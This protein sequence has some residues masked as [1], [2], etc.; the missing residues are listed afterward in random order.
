MENK[1]NQILTSKRYHDLDLARAI[2][3]L[4]L[5]FIHC[6]EEFNAIHLLSPTLVERGRIFLF[7]CMICPSVFM[8]ELGMNITFSTHTSDTELAHRG[9]R[10]ILYFYLLNIAR[11]G[12]PAIVFGLIFK[13][14]D[15]IKELRI[16][17][18]Q[19]DILFFAGAAFLFFALMKHWNVK[20]YH[21][22][23]I[24]IF[25]LAL[26]ILIPNGITQNYTLR[27][28][29]GNIFYVSSGS[30]FPLLSWLIFPTVGYLM[31]GYL[32]KLPDEKSINSFFR[33]MLFG[34]I[35]VLLCTAACLKNYGLNPL[36]IAT[37]PAN[38]YITDLF[39]VL[40]DLAIAG[41]WFSVIHF[42]YGCIH[43]VR[44]KRVADIISRGIL[45]F[46]V[47]QWL[48]VGWIEYLFYCSGY[49]KSL[50]DASFFIISVLV[51][52]ASLTLAVIRQ[53]RKDKKRGLVIHF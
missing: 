35:A 13:Q 32:K 1:T 3:L 48:F 47:I 26:D 25:L 46:F 2:P 31:G 30:C 19:S 12:I 33:D 40:L 43:S 52:A 10:T 15:A 44:I 34:S 45:S 49:P 39:N 4:F 17:L 6:Y 5:P 20:P 38:D 7:L 36:L 28:L 51:F 18:L 41:I 53:I 29:L 16:C 8:M 37:S 42:L 9:I 11:G 14:Y 23:V 22:L 27:A 50:S 24:A 21:I